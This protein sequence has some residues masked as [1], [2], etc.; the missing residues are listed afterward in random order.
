MNDLAKLLQGKLRRRQSTISNQRALNKSRPP[1]PPPPPAIPHIKGKLRA[2]RA[3]TIL[4]PE[5][6]WRGKKE[7]R[8]GRGEDTWHALE[9]RAREEGREG[10]CVAGERTE[11]SIGG[12]KS[13][14][15]LSKKHLLTPLPLL[16]AQKGRQHESSR[17]LRKCFRTPCWRQRERN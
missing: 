3:S 12:S 9:G 2:R 17:A 4:V 11:E 8:E 15:P 14:D 5:K 10:G 16:P 6:D 1:P 13:S 7:G